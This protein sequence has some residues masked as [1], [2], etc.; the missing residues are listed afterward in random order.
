MRA[1]LSLTALAHQSNRYLLA[2]LVAKA[3]RKLHRPNTRLQDTVNDAFGWFGGSKPSAD[4][5]AAEM[6]GSAEGGPA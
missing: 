5:R 3:T 1:D 2:R 4:R 6:A